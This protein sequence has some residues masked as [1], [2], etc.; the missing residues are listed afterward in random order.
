MKDIFLTVCYSEDSEHLVTSPPPQHIVSVSGSAP[1]HLSEPYLPANCKSPLGPLE[2]I[3]EVK[4]GQGT[5][6]RQCRILFRLARTD[7]GG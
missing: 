1:L 3:A 5:R 4:A 7:P 2:E 6:S